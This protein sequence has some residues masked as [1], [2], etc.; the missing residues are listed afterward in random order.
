MRLRLR[1]RNLESSAAKVSLGDGLLLRTPAETAAGT[2]S[3]LYY[4]TSKHHR[5]LIKQT[6]P[7]YQPRRL[8]DA[9]HFRPCPRIG[10]LMAASESVLAF[11]AEAKAR[12]DSLPLV[13]AQPKLDLDLYVQNYV[14]RTRFDRLLFIGKACAPLCVDALKAAVAEAKKGHDV[15]RFKEAVEC[16]RIAAPDEPEATGDDA[17][18]NKTEVA[19]KTETARLEAELKGYKNNLIKESIRMGN[20]DLG[21]HLESIGKLQEASDAYGRMRQDVGTA[22]HIVECI[23]HVTTV[24]L[25][26]RDW[27][28][29]SSSVGKL[30]G[31]QT[32][33]DDK[34]TQ[35]YVKVAS[36]IALLC[37]SH[38]LDAANSF[39]QVDSSAPPAAYANVA[40]PNDIAIYGGLTALATMQRQDLQQRVLDNQAFRTFLEQEPNV[41]KAISLFINGRYS[42]CLSILESVRPDYLLDIYLHKQIPALYSKIRSK[43][44]VQYFVPFSCVTIDSLNTAFGQP[45]QSIEPELVDMVRDGLLKA[46]IDAKDKLL[47][48]VCPDPRVEMQMEILEVARRFEQDAKERLRR[49][50]LIAAG[51]EVIGAHHKHPA[52]AGSNLDT[53]D[54]WYDGNPHLAGRA[55][56]ESRG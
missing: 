48:A 4:E 5:S 30:A 47:V 15:G 34:S 44:I 1:C 35:A 7:S 49:I 20:E 54:S 13:T 24:A 41:R 22:K 40:S 17:W 52:E 33:E 42:S 36:G 8:P 16:L 6:L 23:R 43:C 37:T 21:K 26:R 2:T 50:N 25:Q 14:G 28:V 11:L 29:V 10:H 56:V 51:L 46:R 12:D 19:N 3:P 55:P 9:S 39:L 53:D 27:T 45:G 18:I 32:D 31:V 38:Y